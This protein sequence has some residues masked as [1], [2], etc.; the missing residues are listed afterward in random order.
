MTTHERILRT[1]DGSFTP[2]DPPDSIETFAA[3]INDGGAI[4]G[5]YQTN[6]GIQQGFVRSVDGTY[7]TFDPKSS[8]DTIPE[9]INKS[10]AI[11]GLYVDANG[12]D[13]GFLRMP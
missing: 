8:T 5:A 4:T 6:G 2:I 11:T 1:S 7:A 12:Q 3:G 13:H 9:A 10:G